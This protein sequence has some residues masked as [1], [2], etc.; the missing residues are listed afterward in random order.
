MGGISRAGRRNLIWACTHPGKWGKKY[1]E[2]LDASNIARHVL[3]PEKGEEIHPPP[4]L[5][6]T[7][8]MVYKARL[9]PY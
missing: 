9:I 2:Q 1:I 4:L 8:A 3:T 6:P 5:S 7:P